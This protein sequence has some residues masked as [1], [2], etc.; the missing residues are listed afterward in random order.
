MLD[1]MLDN[2]EWWDNC[3]HNELADKKVTDDDCVLK[4]QLIE[5]PVYLVSVVRDLIKTYNVTEENID[6]K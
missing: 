6:S 4:T 1:N 3:P 2:E 5:V